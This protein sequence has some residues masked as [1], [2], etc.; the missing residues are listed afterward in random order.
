M[1]A[2]YLLFSVP[3]TEMALGAGTE[4]YSFGCECLMVFRI[5]RHLFSFSVNLCI[6]GFCYKH[7]PKEIRRV[8]FLT[9]TE[10]QLKDSKEIEL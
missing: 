7:P 4:T 5:T 1:F 3:S 6:E 8:S 2:V 9:C 10:A